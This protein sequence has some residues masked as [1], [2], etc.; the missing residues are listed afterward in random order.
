MTAQRLLP[1]VSAARRVWC[2]GVSGAGSFP[3]DPTERYINY[4][5]KWD[6]DGVDYY[7]DDVFMHR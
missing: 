7:M 2:F 1:H 4:A 5:M 3:S 6:P